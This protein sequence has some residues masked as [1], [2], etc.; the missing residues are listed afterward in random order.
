MPILGIEGERTP[1]KPPILSFSKSASMS[2]SSSDRDLAILYWKLQRSV[3]TNPGIRGYL[4][5]LTKVLRERRIQAATLNAIGLEL[6]V[7]NQ[8]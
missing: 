6:V 3:H 5:A 1:K 7:N 4:Y 2:E 8:L